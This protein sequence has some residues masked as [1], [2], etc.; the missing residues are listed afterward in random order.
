MPGSGP[1]PGVSGENE[2]GVSRGRNVSGEH[3]EDIFD[4]WDG[5][6]QLQA[7]KTSD[8]EFSSGED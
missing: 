6:K 7:S 2:Q 8:W 1:R 4:I 5:E 3:G